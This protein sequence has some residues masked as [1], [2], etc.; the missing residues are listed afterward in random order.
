ML[1]VPPVPRVATLLNHNLRLT[2]LSL[3]DISLQYDAIPAAISRLKYLQRLT[4]TNFEW[5]VGATKRGTMLLLQACLPL[6]DLTELIMDYR[7]DWSDHDEDSSRSKPLKPKKIPVRLD[8]ETI[9]QESSIARFSQYPSASKI[10]LLHLP[11]CGREMNPLV[12]PLL[13]S[14]LLDLESCTIPWVKRC[15]NP[16]DI[17]RMV[18]LHCPKLKHLTYQS[19]E[20]GDAC[21]DDKFA[22]AFVR[23]SSRLES[24]VCSNF[25]REYGAG[26]QP[27]FSDLVA[28][29]CNT[30]REFELTECW[31]LSSRY[32]QAI[33]S[34]CRELRRFWVKSTF[35]E[36]STGFRFTDASKG[37]WVCTELRELR[38]TLNLHF[39]PTDNDSFDS[40]ADQSRQEGDEALIAYENLFFESFVERK[41]VDLA[42]RRLFTQIG[43]LSKLEKLTLDIDRSDQT[44][45]E[46]GHYRRQLTLAYGNLGEL[47][48]LRNLRSLRLEADFWSSMGQAEMEFMHEQWPL[49]DEIVLV[50]EASKL[51]TLPHWK[52]LFSKRPHLVFTTH[53][54]F[55]RL[56]RQ[57]R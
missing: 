38:L 2:Q 48:G 28:H 36:G 32:Q 40:E 8:L 42:V 13:T 53:T 29:H 51:C 14:G 22:H 41:P 44:T 26:I 35:P 50:G 20:A 34:Q 43:R 56:F 21:E 12:V 4:I 30:L 24:F 5:I 27:I 25:S 55:P 39:D 31:R 23:G 15:R 3:P 54:A 49:L 17:E 37:D 46:E 6:P 57:F 7:V 33:L 45:A 19:A 47:A 1:P 9:I 52:W 10:K 18:Q 16:T 11:G